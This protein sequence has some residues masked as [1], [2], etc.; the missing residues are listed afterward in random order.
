MLPL[1]SLLLPLSARAQ[2]A[3]AFDGQ[4]VRPSADSQVTLWTD[5]AGIRP[6]FVGRLGLGYARDPVL[7]VSDSTGQGQALVGPRSAVVVAAVPVGI[8]PDRQGPFFQ[9]R[10]APGI[11]AVGADNMNEPL[12]SVRVTHRPI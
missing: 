1:L 2:E 6:G 10:Y 7:V 9:R 8:Q 11:H 3:T 12:D 5:D 4:L